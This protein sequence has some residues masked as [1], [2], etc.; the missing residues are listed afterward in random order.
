MSHQGW[1]TALRWFALQPPRSRPRSRT[2]PYLTG[3]PVISIPCYINGCHCVAVTQWELKSLVIF[4]YADNLND[5]DTETI[6]KHSLSTGN[7]SFYS[8]SAVLL[9]C[10]NVTYHP[11]SN[12]CS[13][14]TLFHLAIQALH[15]C[16]QPNMLLPGMH[17]NLAQI[18]R[19]WIAVSLKNNFISFDPLLSIIAQ[20]SPLLNPTLPSPLSRPHSL[21]H[22]STTSPQTTPLT[23]PAPLP[24]SL[25]QPSSRIGLDSS[26]SHTPT[27]PSL[28][29]PPR[30]PFLLNPLAPEFRPST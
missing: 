15:P 9:N 4:L 12:E 17:P 8:L 19:T 7:T 10:R 1:P 13:S 16:P 25:G 22:W 21:I 3:E 2:R 5:P 18:C 11:H 26:D 20:P 23:S 14:R 28:V 30:C 27:F 29:P 24:P 6:V